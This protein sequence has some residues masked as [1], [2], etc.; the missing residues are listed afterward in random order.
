MLLQR[1]VY[2]AQAA[3]GL[4]RL[5]PTGTNIRLAPPESMLDDSPAAPEAEFVSLLQH[6]DVHLSRCYQEI[7]E[8]DT[9]LGNEVCCSIGRC[10]VCSDQ[11]PLDGDSF[12]GHSI[13]R[14][15]SMQ[16]LGSS[17]I[18]KLSF[19][20]LDTEWIEDSN[21]DREPLSLLDYIERGEDYS[22]V[23]RPQPSEEA[24]HENM[25]FGFQHT[26]QTLEKADAPIQTQPTYNGASTS[27]RDSDVL[28]PLLHS[29]LLPMK[30]QQDWSDLE[31][32]FSDGTYH[33]ERMQV[34]SGVDKEEGHTGDIMLV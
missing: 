13:N 11:M 32:L 6:D 33:S 30:D 9:T 5:K 3:C 7:E 25:L 2:D 4:K 18:S 31:D 8:S 23:D 1:L 27:D 34:Y 26:K 17:E 20:P 14:T 19:M 12:S 16:Q 22:S 28:D 29:E 15:T 21:G 24:V 10:Y